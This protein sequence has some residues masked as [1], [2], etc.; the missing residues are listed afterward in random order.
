MAG[1]MFFGNCDKRIKKADQIFIVIKC[2]V[3]WREAS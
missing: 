1:I 2:L 3:V